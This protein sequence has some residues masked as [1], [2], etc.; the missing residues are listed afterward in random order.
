VDGGA[1]HK[2]SVQ[3]I[4]TVV[5]TRHSAPI[6]ANNAMKFNAIFRIWH[7]RNIVRVGKISEV[8]EA[9]LHMFN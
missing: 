8:G 9:M 3:S 5:T 1:E 7:R 4:H 2:R 6:H